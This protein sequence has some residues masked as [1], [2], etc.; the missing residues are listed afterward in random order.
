MPSVRG[1][2]FWNRIEFVGLLPAN[3]FCGTSASS[4]SADS[5]EP[6]SSAR[7]SSA[8]LPFISA[9]VCAKKFASRIAWCS[10]SGLCVSTG[11]RKSQ[12]MSFVPWWMSW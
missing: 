7:T 4:S 2:S 11:A 1:V 8:V 3:T 10:P 5:F 12:G 9:S 6:F